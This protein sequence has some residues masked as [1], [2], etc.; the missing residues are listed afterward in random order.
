M[1]AVI[2]MLLNLS[3]SE[4]IRDRKKGLLHET[5]VSAGVR[6]YIMPYQT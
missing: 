2:I 1:M 5:I 4:L 3:E 6:S